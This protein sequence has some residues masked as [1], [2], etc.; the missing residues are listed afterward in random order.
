MKTRYTLSVYLSG[1]TNMKCSEE[2]KRALYCKS[3][4][5]SIYP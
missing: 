2:P 4:A 5:P 3:V 1:N